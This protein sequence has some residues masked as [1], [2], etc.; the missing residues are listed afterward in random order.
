M[1]LGEWGDYQIMGKRSKDDHT[2]I[3]ALWFGLYAGRLDWGNN[4]KA[5][6]KDYHMAVMEQ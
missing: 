6:E 5:K 3:H 4:T 1:D 2:F